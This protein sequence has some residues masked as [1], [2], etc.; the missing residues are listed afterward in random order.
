MKIKVFQNCWQKEVEKILTQ[1]FF[2]EFKIPCT[3]RSIDIFEIKNFYQKTGGNFWVLENDNE[4]FGTIG[5]KKFDKEIVI[6][7][8]FFVAKNLRRRGWGEKLLQ[9]VLNFSKKNNFKKIY[10]ST[11]KELITG[12]KFYEKNNFKKLK[13][14]PKF[15]G[16][17]GIDK[18]FF[19]K[20]LK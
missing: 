17:S 14:W 4:I 10:L 16:N 3:K 2:N 12:I 7:K 1:D 5:L 11:I 20:N 13:K 8:R 19:V 15:L 6:L 9:N 18:I